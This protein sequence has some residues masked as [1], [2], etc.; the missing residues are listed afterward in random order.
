MR[1]ITSAGGTFP[2]LNGNS[3]RTMIK[4][5]KPLS[6]TASMAW[7]LVMRQRYSLQAAATLL[8]TTPR[9]VE[10]MLAGMVQRRAQRWRM[11]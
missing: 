8:G 1:G 11:A 5:A 10:H 3:E 2:Y 4:T 7:L 6:S 9:R